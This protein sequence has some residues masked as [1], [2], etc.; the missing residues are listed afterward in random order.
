MNVKFT[1]LFNVNL[2][3]LKRDIVLFFI[4]SSLIACVNTQEQ[5]RYAENQQ[6]RARSHTNLGAAYFQQKQLE[7]AL[8]EFNEAKKIDPNFS[9]AYNGLGLVHAALGQDA[10][11]EI[12]F[13]KAIQ[14]DPNNSES[15][16]NYGSFLCARNRIDESIKEFMAAVKNPLYAT[17]AVAYTNA[18]IC[19]VRKNDYFLAEQYLQ[20]ALAL[21]PLFNAPAYHLAALQFKLNRPLEAKASLQNVLLS[22]P[23]PEMLWLAIQL[24]R[25]VGSRDEEASYSL[26]LRR[27]FPESEQAKLLQRGS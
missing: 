2:Y 4:A 25:A 10:V 21:D 12:N 19:A 26:Q 1:G 8:N 24:E 22:N 6:T 3:H 7:I 15:R 5:Q 14:L 20:G 17:P 23:T 27:L 9:L 13:K 18:G 11:A 16:N